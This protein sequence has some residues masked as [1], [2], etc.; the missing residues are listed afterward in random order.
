MKAN[1]GLGGSRRLNPLIA[2]ATVTVMVLGLLG[3]AAITGHPSG[4]LSQKSAASGGV[5]VSVRS[6]A[7]PSC[8]TVEAVRSLTVRG[9]AGGPGAVYRVTVRMDDGSFRTVSQSALPAFAVGDKVRV[10]QGA[11]HGPRP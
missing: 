11:L 7:C 9:E 8:G 5:M 4:A 1:E 2:G 10:M 3:V 6:D